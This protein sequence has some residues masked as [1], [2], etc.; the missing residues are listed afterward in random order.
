[1]QTGTPNPTDLNALMRALAERAEAAERRAREAEAEAE[2][3]RTQAQEAE[4]KA[5]DLEEQLASKDKLI[6]QLVHQ[7]GLLTK[8]LAKASSRPEQLSLQLELD[9]VQARLDELNREKFGASSSERR[10]TGKDKPKKDKKPQTGHGPTPQPDLERQATLHTLPEDARCT[11]CGGELRPWKDHTCDSEEIDVIERTFVVRVHK[12]QTYKCVDCRHLETASGPR[13]LVPGGRYSTDFAAM[14]ATDKYRDALPLDR[15]ARRMG[16]AGLQV[17]RQTLWDQCT[18]LYV[19]LVHNYLALRD[20]ILQREVVHVDETRWR[21]MKKGASKRWWVWALTDGRR[22]YFELA[23]SRGQAPARE[24]LGD[25]DG[26]VVAD[27]YSVYL[28]LEKARSKNGGA[29]LLLPL[30]GE[31]QT[32]PT[33]DYSLAACWMHARRGFI[34]AEKAGSGAAGRILD[35]IGALYKVEADAARLVSKIKDRD[36]RHEAL[37]TARRQLRQLRSRTIVEQLDQALDQ[38][39]TIEGTLLAKAKGW[40]RNGWDQLMPF[41]ADGRVPLDNGVAERII[42]GVVLG[43]NVSTPRRGLP[44][45]PPPGDL[46]T[47]R[48]PWPAPQRP[49]AGRTLSI[50]MKHPASRSARSP[51]RPTSTRA[52]W[53]GGAASSD[54]RRSARRAPSSSSP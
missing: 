37:V 17:T 6:E 21:L 19:L 9:K 53:P 15:Q 46:P 50:S 52:P 26:I 38:L 25:Y 11:K 8:R 48:K 42:R 10:S 14:V 30:D 43:R 22:A 4:A 41:L 40:I 36:A 16:E 5:R 28:A 32:V 18:E 44:R 13:R 54:A 34:R 24:L 33:P 31:A 2:T 27:R 3:A 7:V 29:R 12:R 20:R 47:R 39:V 23:S 49:S 51:R 35:L 45:L 1:M